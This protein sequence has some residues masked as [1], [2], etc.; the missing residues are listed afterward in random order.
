MFSLGFVNGEIHLPLHFTIFL[1]K[2]TLQHY[3]IVYSL[4]GNSHSIL[5][6]LGHELLRRHKSNNRFPLEVK[7]VELVAAEAHE[8]KG[9]LG[10]MR[11]QALKYTEREEIIGHTCTGNRG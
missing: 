7:T 2:K 8:D 9:F 6:S 4:I 3:T 11:A 5:S 1:I 10:D